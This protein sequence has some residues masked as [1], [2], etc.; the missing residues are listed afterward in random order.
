MATIRCLIVLLAC[1]ALASAGRHLPGSPIVKVKT[2]CGHLR[3]KSASNGEI[4][5]TLSAKNHRH[6][7]ASTWVAVVNLEGMRAT[8]EPAGSGFST[9]AGENSWTLLPQTPS[10][11]HVAHGAKVS[12]TVCGFTDD[13]EEFAASF[14]VH[15]LYN[16][17]NPPHVIH[18]DDHST[19]PF[20]SGVR[21]H[22]DVPVPSPAY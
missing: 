7:S 8:T 17:L 9:P 21:P 14:E 2:S 3:I 19:C 6:I 16:G 20:V 5:A 12:A 22:P 18:L 13:I 1:A 15:F 10:A 11:G 4:C